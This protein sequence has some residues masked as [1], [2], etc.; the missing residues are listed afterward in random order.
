MGRRGFR[1]GGSGR[2]VL[3]GARGVGL[4]FGRLCP[5]VLC[6]RSTVWRGKRGLGEWVSSS[7]CLLGLGRGW[8]WT[9]LYGLDLQL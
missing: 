2:I 8:W 7:D 4:G 3:C 5:S 6:L 9:N 1:L